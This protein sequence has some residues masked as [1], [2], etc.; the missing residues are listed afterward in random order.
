MLSRL[1]HRQDQ[2]IAATLYASAVDRARMPVFYRHFGVADTI[3]GR[4]DMVTLQVILL[5]NR[6][7]GL[8][9]KRVARLS[10]NV[11]DSMFMDM[12]RT[13]RELG[14]GDQG[15]PHRVKKMAQAFYGRLSAYDTALAAP[16]D[17]ALTEAL[18]RNLYRGAEVEPALVRQLAAHVR[19]VA[20]TYA[21][22]PVEIFLAG[23]LP[24]APALQETLS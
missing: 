14:V 18:I 21:A 23:S 4:F 11:F 1:F 13:L 8:T 15:V 16:D 20:A 22:T 2:R 6:F 24:A 3:D 9:D 5:L 19:Q 12:D 7:K 10:Q 17:T